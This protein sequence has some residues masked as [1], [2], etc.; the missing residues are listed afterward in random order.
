MD[1]IQNQGKTPIITNVSNQ[2]G[3][4]KVSNPIKTNITT[5]TPIKTVVASEVTYNNENT[6]C[7]NIKFTDVPEK[8]GLGKILYPLARKYCIFDDDSL[9]QPKE[10][11]NRRDMLMLLMNYLSLNP[12][13]NDQS[14]M[15]D[16]S[17]NDPVQGYI[18]KAEQ[19]GI[20]DG[21]YFYPNK[22]VTR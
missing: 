10:I 18:L 15:L 11:I 22:R 9:F 8:S 4:T 5:S 3:T 20:I 7:P 12:R 13:S 1:F 19:M 17:V 16:V 21:I 2:K 14:S 6:A